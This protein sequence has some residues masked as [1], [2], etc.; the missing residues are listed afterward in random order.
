M[1]YNLS[2][3]GGDALDEL[4]ELVTHESNRENAH[5]WIRT[6]LGDLDEAFEG[7]MREAE[8]HSWWFLIKFEPLFKVF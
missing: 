6:V 1:T 7:L 2:G 3:A 5:V 8:L 4:K